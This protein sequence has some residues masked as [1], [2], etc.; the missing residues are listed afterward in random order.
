MT[1]TTSCPTGW[2][3]RISRSR[4]TAYLGYVCERYLFGRKDAEPPIATRGERAW[5]AVYAIASFVYRAVV[6]FAIVLF[7]GDHMFLLAVIFASLVAVGWLGGPLA[8]GLGHLLA[9]PSLRAVRGRAI[10]VTCLIAG[11]VVWLVGFVPVPYRS[12][13]EGVIWIPEEATVRAQADGFVERIVA[14]PGSQVRRGDV[15]LALGDPAL[16]AR[17]REL[18][19]RRA[20][21]AARLQEQQYQDLVKAELLRLELTYATEQ[22]A[23]AR[24]RVAELTIHA[25][26]AGTFVVPV[27]E[28]LTGRFVR[29]G[30]VVGYTVELGTVTV[31]SVVHQDAIDLVRHATERVDVRLAERLDEVFPG[32]IRREVPGVSERL[33]TSALGT[34]GGGQVA[35]DPR[36]QQGVTAM[37]RMFQIDVELPAISRFLNVGG[38]AYLRFDHGRAPLIRQ[39]YQHM[40]QIFL[41]RFNV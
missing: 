13:A 14:R 41:S 1:A 32:V 5:F 29:K 9:G 8:K 20:E 30:E 21:V 35:V 24:A 3:S 38:R 39:W 18:E 23:E 16:A 6:V 27:P 4:A 28:D 12:R 2:R 11:L 33:P 15:L 40:R 17:V 37:E 25:G 10:A 22:L 26:T 31:R 7:L 34:E 19:A 36:D